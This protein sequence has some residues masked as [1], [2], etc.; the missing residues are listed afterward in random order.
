[1]LTRAVSFVGYR[2]RT[3]F[4]SERSY[5]LSVVLLVG[6]LGGLS[7]GAVAAARSTESSFSDYVASS[8]VPNLIV[9]DGVI[10]PAIGLDSAYNP[11][12]LRK[13]SH[14]PHVE[15]VADTV[16]LNVGPLSSKG[17]P[18]PASLSIPGD[19]SVNGLYFTEDP[20]AITAGR[21]PDPHRADEFVLDAATAKA[22]GYHVGEE[23]PVGWLTNAEA[24]SGNLAL[25][26]IIP[27]DQRAKVELVGIAGAQVTN[28]FQD[29]DE[30]NNQAIML[31]TPALTNKLLACCSNTMLTALTLQDGNRYLSAVEAEVKGVLP[32]GLPFVYVQV[33]DRVATANDTLRPEAIALAVFGGIAG[34][35][36]LLIAGQ[37]VSRRMRMR[38]ADLDIIRALGASPSMI[39]GDDLIGTV[40]AVA[41]G[42][43]LAGLVALGLSPLAPLGPV[44][45]FLP[46][47]VH[48]DWAVIGLGLAGL[49]L[50]L[51]A[52]A[53][54]ASWRARP[55]RARA[56]VQRPP[57]SRV[58]TAAA[59]SGLPPSAITGVRFA[60]EPGVG[61]SAVPV[62]SAILGAILAVTVVVA[63]VTFGSSLSTLV[64]HPAL[65]G[66]N[67]TYVMD[68]GGGLGDVPGQAAARLLNTDPL[69]E[70]WTGVYY[71]TLQLDG[72]NIPAMGMPTHA[73]VA[74]PLLSGH[75][76][77]AADQ[78][79][80]GAGTLHQLHKRVG[81]T[82]VVRAHNGPPVKLTI[83]GTATLPPI[84]VIGSSH[85]EMGSGALLSY[86]LIPP[87]AR[88]LFEGTPGPNAVLV[89]TKGG[90]SPQG[91][92]SLQAIGRKLDIAVNGGSVLPVQRPAEILNYGSLGTTPVL[93]GAALAAGAAVALAITLV[94]SVRRRRRDLAILKT[95]GFTRRQLASAVAVQAGVASVIGCAI[96][97]P[98]GVALG[99]AL[100][101]LFAGEISAVPYP[102]V[103]TGTI[104]VIGIVAIALAVV[105]ATVPGRIAARTSTSQLLRAE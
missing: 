68:G 43:V 10:N 5:Y 24:N 2:F 14:L 35:A 8:H 71:S 58:T 55:G 98:A 36:A 80:L 75:G 41:V 32:K 54:L 47:G 56:G 49:L 100:W 85:L 30:A 29:Q 53:A 61:R 45:P 38:A 21:M 89:R 104:V 20:V 66:W 25:N 37:V 7:M 16:Q 74:P 22:F 6:A 95:L 9:L 11:V 82:L 46:V 50:A 57:S 81:D 67:W 93:L 91:L 96:G 23:V 44:R 84:G 1:M 52:I 39:F 102:T 17:L 15:R 90:A 60:L 103:P 4:R 76:L 13:L 72:V 12:L 62:R 73:A 63:T 33:K 79:V 77:D 18:L 69:V 40:G 64:S 26:S 59:R 87:A 28:L 27:A 51:V 3:T 92:R 99:R 70:S 105:V 48:A 94:T 65:Y 97:I 19:A 83:V 101:N 88:N 42:S 31:F 86:R 34:I 78:V